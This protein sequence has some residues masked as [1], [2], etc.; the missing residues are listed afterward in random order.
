MS[1]SEIH[2]AAASGN[3]SALQ[4]SLATGAS[5]E[6]PDENGATPLFIA[7]FYGQFNIVEF[8][9]QQGANVNAGNMVNYT[10]LMAASRE[11]RLEIVEALLR[12]KAD[13]EIK[14]QGMKAIH[15]SLMNTIPKR[16]K[17]PLET[18]TRL[19]EILKIFKHHGA[20]LN[21]KGDKGI[22][23]LMNAA[24]WSLFY[25][26]EYLLHEGANPNEKDNDGETAEDYATKKLAKNFDTDTNA[27]CEKI[28]QIL[29]TG[30]KKPWWKIV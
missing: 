13:P 5:L 2:A 24:W 28:I 8:L 11:K 20:D 21:A 10:P 4:L 30:G 25:V 23:P 16:K 6:A 1:K 14:A 7:A 26:T 19:I 12:A 27:R 17:L 3:L 22:T 18:E 15:W 9:L 29:K